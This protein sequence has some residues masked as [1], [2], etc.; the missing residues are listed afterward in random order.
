[1]SDLPISIFDMP[2]P[3]LVDL[4]DA[5]RDWSHPVDYWTG[6]VLSAATKA[7]TEAVKDHYDRVHGSGAEECDCD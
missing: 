4:R 6:V 5:I 3:D 1:M 7:Y 2:P